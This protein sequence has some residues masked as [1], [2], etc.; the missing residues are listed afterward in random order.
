MLGGVA[1]PSVAQGDRSGLLKKKTRNEVEVMGVL[2]E[3]KL[4]AEKARARL[5][6][7]E[8][9]Q[10]GQRSIV[11]RRLMSRMNDLHA[12]F[13]EFQQQLNLVNPEVTSDFYITDLCTLK[14]LRQG[15]YQLTSDNSGCVGK[16]TFH[17]ALVGRG[18][19]EVKLPSKLIA[20][21]K[22][23]NLWRYGFKFK[24]KE[25][26]PGRC[27]LFIESYVPVSFEFEADA[28]R[29]AI[30]LKVKNKPMPGVSG[31]I[32]DADQIDTGLM[33]ET[34]KYILDKPSR[35]DDLSGNT[36]PEDTL[37][38]IREQLKRE[39]KKGRGAKKSLS[40]KLFRRK[41]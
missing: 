28:E 17:Y 39:K 23:E 12:Y 27:S 19:R 24:L 22:R 4:Q 26:S 1:T 15:G 33:D 41:A 8:T 3:L 20:E 25:Y 30:R 9:S 14:R 34:A 11:E 18:M 7:Q 40:E 31:Y 32:Y 35:F 10:K 2:D 5:E 16:F 6:E 38:R 13:K 36:V 29:A 21:Q 37:V